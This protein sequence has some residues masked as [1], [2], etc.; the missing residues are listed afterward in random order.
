M[1][2]TNPIK[3]VDRTEMLCGG[4]AEVTI[5]FDAVPQLETIPTDIVLILDRSGSMNGGPLTMAKVAARELIRTVAAASGDPLGLTLVNGSR[6]GLASFSGTA[7]EDL[8]LSTDTA[9]LDGAVDA[10]QGGGSTNHQAAFETARAM[11]ESSTAPRRV[12]IL[13]TDGTTTV[14]DDPDLV[15]EDMKQSGIEIFCIGLGADEARLA[16]WASTPTADHVAATGDV[17]Q[18]SRVFAQTA[19]QVVRAGALD[20]VLLETLAPGFKLVRVLGV[21]HGSVE[22]LDGRTLRW[23]AGTVGAA[24]PETA[25]LTFEITH[26]GE[27]GGRMPVNQSLTYTDRADGQLTFPIPEVDVICDGPVI[28]PESCPPPVTVRVEGCQDAAAVEAGE[29]YLSGLG[30]IL[31]VDV[32]V[33]NVCPGRKVAA[34]VLLTELGEDGVEHDRGMKT[35]LIPAQDGTDCRDIH[36]KCI[37][38]VVPEVLDRTGDPASICN[39]R[40]FRTRVLANYVDTD[41]TCCDPQTVIV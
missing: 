29:V 22:V 16:D 35:V 24:G 8:A 18:L 4:T 28:C 15:A 6:M 20:A 33:K 34:A 1:P 38:F 12:A 21:S 14:G 39:A 31:Q 36:L 40:R 13:F 19:A 7:R 2:V 32:V 3:S 27:E 9:A 5:G 25:S 11:L 37:S 10:L 30:R 41:F 17:N 23:K 26:I